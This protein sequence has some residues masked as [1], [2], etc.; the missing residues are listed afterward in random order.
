MF[1]SS[2]QGG[3]R[4]QR[5]I[6]VPIEVTLSSGSSDEDPAAVHPVPAGEPNPACNLVDSTTS[7]REAPE[8]RDNP[9]EAV[10]IIRGP[11]LTREQLEAMFTESS[12]SEEEEDEVV[13]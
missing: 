12:S 5:L 9:L 7:D 1:M 10:P 11:R 8:T 2:L 6:E 3:R 4:N 13:Q